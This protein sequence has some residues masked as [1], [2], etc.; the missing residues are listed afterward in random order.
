MPTKEPFAQLV[1]QGR[2]D[3][4]LRLAEPS[5]E[6]ENGPLNP[7]EYQAWRMAQK[8]PRLIIRCNDGS[9]QSMPYMALLRVVSNTRFS[10]IF[11]LVFNYMSVTVTGRNLG[12]VVD[13]IDDHHCRMLT[14]F[15]PQAFD[16]PEA[17]A[18]IIEGIEVQDEG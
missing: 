18:P 11:V 14:Q 13:A 15:D 10:N 6:A 16:M 4:H 5:H 8:P 2:R 12:A 7:R 1:E 17:S 9:S 3:Q